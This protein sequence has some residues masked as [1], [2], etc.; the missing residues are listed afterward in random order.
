[1]YQKDLALNDLQ[2]CHENKPKQDKTKYYMF[3]KQCFN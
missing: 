2:W 1:M 3:M